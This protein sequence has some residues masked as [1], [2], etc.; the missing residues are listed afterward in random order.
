MACYRSLVTLDQNSTE[1]RMKVV[2]IGSGGREHTICWQLARSP[3]VRE[4]ISCPGNPG[5]E[6]L[7]TCW[8]D[9]DPISSIDEFIQ[10]CLSEEI[11]HVVIGPEAPLV[12]G[13]ADRIREAG[14]PCFGPGAE[15]AQLEGSK[16]YSKAFMERHQIPTSAYRTIDSIEDLDSALDALPEQVVVKASGLAAG[17]GVIVCDNRDQAR[18]AATEMLSGASFG[19]SG[20]TVVIEERMFGPEVSILVVVKGTDYLLLPT[21][22]DHKPLLDGNQGPNTG[23]M[24]A[25][26]PGTIV[27]PDELT[28]IQTQIIEP[29][30]KGLVTDGIEYSGILYAGLMMTD[31]GPRVL[32]YNCRLGDPE[33]QPVLMRLKSDF[34]EILE[35]TAGEGPSTAQVEWDP[36][37]T[38]CLVLSSEGYPASPRKGQIIEG[39]LYSPISAETQVFHAGTASGPDSSCQVSGGRVL[40]ITA[41]GDSLESARKLA[42]EKAESIDFDGKFYRSDIGIYHE[43]HNKDEALEK[44]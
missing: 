11:D 23:G 31:T 32:E 33:T 4:V 43:T 42:Y 27:G 37:S 25:F 12:A 2:V 17:K 18:I 26:S 13:V 6:Q 36:R 8:R 44:Q 19:E 14:I 39:D 16:A 15:A 21:S 38:L 3:R 30:L 34:V 5:M 22:Q 7:G 40:G 1:V 20:K 41:I 29:T 10:R 35:A 28:E 24:G 9:C